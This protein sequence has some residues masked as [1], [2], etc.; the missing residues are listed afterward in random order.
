GSDTQ[1]DLPLAIDANGAGETEWTAPQGAKMGDYDL[2]VLVKD[3]EG[4]E[5]TLWTGQSFKVDEY[6]LPTMKASV[7]G[8]KDAAV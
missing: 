3:A 8:P 7:A 4:K 1:Y 5:K 2:T 6:K